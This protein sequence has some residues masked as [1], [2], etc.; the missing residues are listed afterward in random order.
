MARI[1]GIALIGLGLAC[2]P[3]WPF[4]GMLTYCAL[5]M[6]YLAYLALAGGL[7]GVLLWPAVVLHLLLTT[8]IAW[9]SMKQY[10]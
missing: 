9:Q 1:T 5:V 7:G 6:F 3:E 8:L 4:I 10:R 2:G